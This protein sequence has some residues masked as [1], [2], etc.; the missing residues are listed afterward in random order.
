MGGE[1]REVALDGLGV[2]YVGVDAGEEGEV[3]LFGGD[4][5]AGLGHEG[6]EAEGFERDGFAAGVGAADDEL[7]GGGGEDDGEWDWSFGWF[8][9]A[10]GCCAHAEFE[11]R[12]ARGKKG[13]WW[14]FDEMRGSLHCATD[15]TAVCCSGQDDAS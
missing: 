10:R 12:V 2:A 11:E 14:W 7:S 6:E 15:D 4:G 3:C 8:V 5:D 13:E 1:A 9:C